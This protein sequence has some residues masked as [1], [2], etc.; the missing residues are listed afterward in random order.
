MCISIRDERSKPYN[1]SRIRW[2]YLRL[3]DDQLL[4]R[5]TLDEWKIW[6]RYKAKDRSSSTSVTCNSSADIGFHVFTSKRGAI[7][8]AEEDVT[9]AVIVKLTVN[10]FNASGFWKGRKCETWRQ[11]T[12]MEVYTQSG[13]HNITKRFV[14]K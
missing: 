10:G 7:N 9:G 2:K 8:A 11:A 13:R 12:I 5:Y 6:K 1:T 3:S 14:K 4:S